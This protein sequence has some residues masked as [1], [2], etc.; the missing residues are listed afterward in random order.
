VDHPVEKS[1]VDVEG[2]FETARRIAEQSTVLLKNNGILPIS[3]Q[4][5]HSIA[6]IG[7]HADEGMISGGG[8]AQVDPPGRPPS[9][10]QAHVWFPTSPLRAIEAKARGAHVEFN[11]GADPTSAAAIAK[12]ADIALVFAHQW[13]SEGMD[14]PNLSLPENQDA[15]IEQ[16]AAAN[17][18]TV[19]VLETGTAVTMPW[20]DK[21]SGVLEAWYPGI[22]G[23]EALAKIVAGDVNP[24]G[25]LAITF[26][27]SDADLPHPNL[28]LPPPESQP[29]RP[30]PGE[31]I[32]DFMA[33]MQKGLPA[34]Q[35]QYDEGLKVGYK[36]YDAEKK[37]PLFPFGFGLSYTTYAYSGL[38]VKTADGLTVSFTVRNT[39]RRAGTEIAQVY[40]SFPDAA[41]E[42]PKRL[43]GWA[44]VDLAPGESKPVTITIPQDRYTVYDEAS[45]SWKLVPGSYIVMVG[46]SSRDLP[47]TKSVTLQ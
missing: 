46:A 33:Q 6:V 17:P 16:V 22:R 38:S 29:H 20:I 28:V 7:A 5:I 34:F 14:L 42:P 15:L 43:I 23:S 36:W 45:D 26:P 10:W 47:L 32:S 2:G 3:R 21:V 31:N 39:G 35:V 8:S 41:G 1:V 30:K 24:S 18:H 25:K 4:Q 27:K 13:T 19:V 40:T 44:R 11:S 12:E 9:K 37:D